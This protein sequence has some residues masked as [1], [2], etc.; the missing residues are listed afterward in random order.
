MLL[1]LPSP[2]NNARSGNQFQLKFVYVV[3]EAMEV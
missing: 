3:D 1:T 2:Y